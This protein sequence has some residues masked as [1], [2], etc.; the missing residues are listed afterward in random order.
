M[1]LAHELVTLSLRSLPTADKEVNTFVNCGR[2]IRTMLPN[3]SFN[4]LLL[5]HQGNKTNR[6][7]SAG[8]ATCW[9]QHGDRPTSLATSIA[10]Q[11]ALSSGYCFSN[12]ILKQQ[13]NLGTHSVEKGLKVKGNVISLSKNLIALAMCLCRNPHESEGNLNI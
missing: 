1:S 11:I 9:N 6:C 12:V 4:K 8:M 7:L 5:G 2:W 13:K 3:Q 10:I